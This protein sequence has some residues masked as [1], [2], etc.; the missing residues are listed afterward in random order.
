MCIRYGGCVV[1]EVDGKVV[2]ISGV[3]VFYI[4]MGFSCIMCLV[5]KGEVFFVKRLNVNV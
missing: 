5:E 4:L 1:D 2:E 3:G